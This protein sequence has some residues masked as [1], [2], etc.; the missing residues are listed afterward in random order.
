MLSQSS[1]QEIL[2]KLNSKL[3]Y[4]L[5]EENLSPSLRQAITNLAKVQ[6]HLFTIA[7]ILRGENSRIKKSVILSAAARFG[8]ESEK[9]ERTAYADEI[10]KLHLEIDSKISQLADQVSQEDKA[11]QSGLPPPQHEGRLEPLQLKCPLCGAALPLPT[12]RLV[13]CQYCKA[14]LSVQDVS[15]QIKSIIQSI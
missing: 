15:S 12:G 13:Q 3:G 4:E 10:N 14:T 1:R 5:N 11:S 6:Q 8:R 9:S 7:E 2:R